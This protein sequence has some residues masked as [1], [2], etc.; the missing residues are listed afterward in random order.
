MRRTAPGGGRRV[1]QPGTCR[2]VALQQHLLT[3]QV[4]WHADAVESTARGRNGGGKVQG[5]RGR[6]EKKRKDHR[7][8]IRDGSW[9]AVRQ[10][11]RFLCQLVLVSE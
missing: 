4:M 11:L 1:K 6:K 7:K 5:Q 8:L 2:A 10:D 3:Y 9:G